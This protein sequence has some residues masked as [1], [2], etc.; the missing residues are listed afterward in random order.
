MFGTYRCLLA[1]ATGM[2]GGALLRQLLADPACSAVTV[3]A[4]RPLELK[5]ASLDRSKLRVIIADFDCLGD[6]LDD[7]AV[8][9]VF[10]ALGTTI[11]TAGSQEAFRKVD[12]QYPLELARWAELSGAKHYMVITAM[13]ASTSSA[14]FY[15]RV[16]GEL[17][18]RLAELPL[19]SIHFFQPSLLHGERQ[20]FRLV[21]SIGAVLSKGI[22]WLLV[23][24]L[25]PYRPIA[26]E[27]VASAMRA[28]AR[29]AASG[30]PAHQA[31]GE[32]KRPTV[33]TYPSD[34]I[35]AMAVHTDGV[36]SSAD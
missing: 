34:M 2:V 9:V 33:Y 28:A 36:N 19:E 10:C 8:D 3:L 15:S 5:D 1:G 12:Y 11:K 31:H 26:G 24:P 22:S 14:F 6:A 32:N 13:G 35:A 25:R 23:G 17:Q 21:E 16:K 7:V 18:E 29:Q 30:K 4:R 27:A 20:T